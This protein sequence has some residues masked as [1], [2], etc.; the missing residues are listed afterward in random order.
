[1]TPTLMEMVLWL[2]EERAFTEASVAEACG[3]SQPTVHRIKSGKVVRP[4][5]QAGAAIQ[6]LYQEEAGKDRNQT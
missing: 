3:V 4:S 6:H 5:W 2:I 1:M